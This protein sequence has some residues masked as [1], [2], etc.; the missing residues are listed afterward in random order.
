MEGPKGA[1]F[2]VNS[3]KGHKESIAI[4]P[5]EDKFLKKNENEK[6]K[7][8]KP[9]SPKP[10]MPHLS[11]SQRFTKAK[12]DSQFVK[13]LDVRKKLYVNIPFIDALSQMWLYA[14]CLKEILSK[15]KKN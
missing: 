7:E 6:S 4:L 3:E 10:Y 14:K 15:K 1:R 11:F 13:F 5:S 8:P 2:E 12:L 9:P